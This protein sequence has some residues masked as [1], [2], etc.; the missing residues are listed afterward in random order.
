MAQHSYASSET[1]SECAVREP[2]RLQVCM[3]LRVSS[4][5]TVFVQ[6]TAL[7]TLELVCGRPLRHTGSCAK[8]PS[9]MHPD[10]AVVCRPSNLLFVRD[11]CGHGGAGTCELLIRGFYLI[12]WVGHILA[13]PDRCCG[14]LLRQSRLRARLNTS[15]LTQRFPLSAR[16][17]NL[18]G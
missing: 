8:P 1:C 2:E 13:H 10:V 3:G 12:F 17:A 5:P 4:F 6:V 16:L 7:P 14:C 11:R 15:T 18:R 9:G